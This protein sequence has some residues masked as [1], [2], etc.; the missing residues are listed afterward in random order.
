A[1]GS[2]HRTDNAQPAESTISCGIVA[3]WRDAS[4]SR[5]QSANA[6]EVSWNT[7]R[8]AA[9][10]ADASRRTARGNGGSLAAAGAA[11]RIFRVPW[12]ARF[13]GDPVVGFIR[14]QKFG[15]VRVA[16]QDCSGFS[17]SPHQHGVRVRLILFT[18]KRTCCAR[19]IRYV[20]TAFYR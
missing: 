13:A 7:N 19:P 17:E 6:A 16:Q 11:R 15:C 2:R 20:D 1:D 18:Q 14:H 8:T 3:G 12:I 9:V 10:A 5:L 4:R